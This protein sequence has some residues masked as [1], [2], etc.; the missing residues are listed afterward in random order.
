M[1]LS[2]VLILQGSS[3]VKGQ[4]QRS[5]SEVNKNLSL[6]ILILV[7]YLLIRTGETLNFLI[8]ARK[9]ASIVCF[10]RMLVLLLLCN[11]AFDWII[12]L[13]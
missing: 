3:F 9:F 7:K 12:L 11:L 1:F 13:Q 5:R 10:L 8:S 6:Q 4:I 2:F